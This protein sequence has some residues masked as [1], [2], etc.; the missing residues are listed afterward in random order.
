[1]SNSTEPRVRVGVGTFSGLS[2]SSSSRTLFLSRPTDSRMPATWELVFGLGKLGVT[3]WLEKTPIPLA[4]HAQEP[5]T[6]VVLSARCWRCLIQPSNSPMNSPTPL[7]GAPAVG[8]YCQTYSGIPL[9]VKFVGR[10]RLL[11][12]SMVQGTQRFR[13]VRAASLRN[14]LRP[15]WWFILS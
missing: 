15:V 9:S 2:E 11:W 10:D 8:V 14:T 13:Q 5:K 3:R 4:V 7:P 1:M 6:R 12:N